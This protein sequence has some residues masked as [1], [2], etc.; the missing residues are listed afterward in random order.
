MNT[1]V[2]ADD[3]AA[4]KLKKCLTIEVF[5]KEIAGKINSNNFLRRSE[6]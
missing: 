4:E 5:Q 3:T 2:L 6:K 1:F